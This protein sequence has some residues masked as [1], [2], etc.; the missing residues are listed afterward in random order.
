MQ[1]YRIKSSAASLF[2][3]FLPQARLW[4]GRY[5]ETLTLLVEAREGVRDLER[6]ARPGVLRHHCTQR[7]PYLSAD[8]LALEL[9]ASLHHGLAFPEGYAPAQRK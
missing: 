6:R 1:Q 7:S 3:C 8:S 9:E 4:E 2:P 5:A